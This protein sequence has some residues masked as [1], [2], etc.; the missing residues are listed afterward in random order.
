[1]IK[2]ILFAMCL[3]L[4]GCR[5]CVREHIVKTAVKVKK[6]KS[7]CKTKGCHHTYTYADPNGGWWFYNV[8][9]ASDEGPVSRDLPSGGSWTKSASAPKEEEVESENEVDVGEV[10]GGPVDDAG[11]DSD[12]GG[13]VGSDGGGDSGGGGDGGGD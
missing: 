9:L 11:S 5:G 10:D 2:F 8:V 6:L 3:S 1:M 7:E 13:D 12:S 4:V